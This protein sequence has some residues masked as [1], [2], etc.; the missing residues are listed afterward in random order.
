MSSWPSALRKLTVLISTPMESNRK[1]KPEHGSLNVQV[2]RTLT[3]QRP[4][5]HPTGFSEPLAVH[6]PWDTFFALRSL[7]PDVIISGQLGARTLLSSFYSSATRTPLIVYA[8]LSEHQERGRGL[9]RHLL[10]RWLIRRASSVA[11]NGSSGARYLRQMGL[12]EDRLFHVPYSAVQNRFDE[13]PITRPADQAHKLL[14][15]GQLIDRKG[16]VPFVETLARV[17]A[18]I[19]M[20]PSSFRSL[21]TVRWSK[22]SA[23]STGPAICA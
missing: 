16:L 5:K 21:A 12:A 20:R 22:H 15:A 23:P 11:V 6:I 7:R 9:A 1:W 3:I 8:S 17:G 10:R 13:L 14:Y 2:Q 18:I 4:W 19:A